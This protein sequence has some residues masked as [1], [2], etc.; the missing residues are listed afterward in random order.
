MYDWSGMMVSLC[1]WYD[2]DKLEC[3]IK[4]PAEASYHGGCEGNVVNERRGQS[5]DPHH[6]DN[7]YSQA[8]VFWYRLR[9]EIIRA[10]ANC[11]FQHHSGAQA[12]TPLLT[13]IS[14]RLWRRTSDE[15]AWSVFD[16]NL[17]FCYL[18]QSPRVTSMLWF[19]SSL[20]YG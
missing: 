20:W 4:H 6:Q 1:V 16:L 5:R 13:P 12:T 10:T 9:R 7:G 19:E 11:H 14:S 18:I 2:K 8:L 15:A 17:L 3:E